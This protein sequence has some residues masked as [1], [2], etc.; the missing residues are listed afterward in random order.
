MEKRQ[1]EFNFPMY[2]YSRAQDPDDLVRVVRR[3]EELG[4]F[5]V[6][7]PEHL[8]HPTEATEREATEREAN[9]HWPDVPTL[10]AYLAGFTER[11]RFLF[12]VSV[13]PYHPPI[14]YA[15]QLATL[16][17]VSKGRV[18]LGVG[19]GWFEEEFARLSLPFAERGAM[20][21][22]YLRAMIELWTSDRPTFSGKYVSF[23]DV[24]FQPK[25]AQKP[26]MPIFVGGTGIRP[27][28]RVAELGA[29]W[30]PMVGTVEE[31]VAFFEH[32][33][34]LTAERGRDPEALWFYGNLDLILDPDTHQATL[35]ERVVP[36]HVSAPRF[37]NMSSLDSEQAIAAIEQER[38]AG[39]NLV[40][41]GMRWDTV[42][43]LIAGLEHFAA[44]IIPKFR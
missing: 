7:F 20:T 25:P 4:Y 2:P 16:D 13:L 43:D 22:E 34:Q 39:V 37:A 26:H 10:I 12:G 32:V 5:S 38:A 6:G 9:E 8:F 42:D 18:V 15:K 31:R 33:K 11:I 14:Q 30:Q 27:A 29:G 3:A 40:S 17:M 19:T 28:R 44:V 41:I 23:R 1:L 35:V 36:R 24:T 21:D